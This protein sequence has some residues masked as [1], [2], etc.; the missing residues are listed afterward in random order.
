VVTDPVHSITLL[1]ALLL[2]G[3]AYILYKVITYD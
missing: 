3:T 1:M 2:L